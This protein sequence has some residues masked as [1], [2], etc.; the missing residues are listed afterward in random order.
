MRNLK[1][2]ITDFPDKELHHFGFRVVNEFSEVEMARMETGQAGTFKKYQLIVF[3]QYF[4]AVEHFKDK[5]IANGCLRPTIKK[6]RVR[7][8]S[9][10]YKIADLHQIT[11]P[12]KNAKTKFFLVEMKVGASKTLLF[13]FSREKEAKMFTDLF[14]NLKEKVNSKASSNNLFNSKSSNIKAQPAGWR[15][16]RTALKLAGALTSLSIIRWIVDWW[17]TLRR[18]L[19]R[20]T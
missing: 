16:P 6:T 9:E 13:R 1:N 3:H 2:T 11:E 19:S 18:T 8:F 15:T 4:L 20:P 10:D 5:Q 7:R 17:T 14:K 12:V